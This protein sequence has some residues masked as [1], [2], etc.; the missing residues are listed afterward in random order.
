ML[1][2]D[3][4]E[5]EKFWNYLDR[6]VDRVNNGYRLCVLRD[7][8]KLVGDRMRAGVTDSFV[9]LGGNDSGRRVIDFYAERG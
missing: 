1:D 2:G 5:R 9:V 7:P 6:V 8:N 4:K 3:V